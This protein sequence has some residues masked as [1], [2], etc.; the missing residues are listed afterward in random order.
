VGDA[1]RILTYLI[2][3]F[4]G[5]SSFPVSQLGKVLQPSAF[6]QKGSRLVVPAAEPLSR[7][8]LCRAEDE[9]GPFTVSIVISGVWPSNAA[10]KKE[11]ARFA[12]IGAT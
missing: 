3:W 1:E 11:A 9:R 10:I 5:S 8:G 4:L 7:L 6:A 12:G 2:N